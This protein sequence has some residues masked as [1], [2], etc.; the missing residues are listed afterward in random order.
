MTVSRLRRLMT[1]LEEQVP[2][3]EEQI[4]KQIAAMSPAERRQRLIEIIETA[5]AHKAAIDEALASGDPKRVRWARKTQQGP[6]GNAQTEARRA[7]ITKL[8]QALRER[9][10]AN[11]STGA[12]PIRTD[13][14]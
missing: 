2:S 10:A 1:K 13:A 9:L 12:I 14:P 5:K 7:E 6:K 11:E 8:M 4:K 3:I